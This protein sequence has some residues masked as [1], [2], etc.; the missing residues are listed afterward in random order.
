MI[1]TIEGLL[2]VMIHIL[3]MYV[4][5]YFLVLIMQSFGGVEN[6]DWVMFLKKFGVQIA[7]WH[8]LLS[9]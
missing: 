9:S 7:F 1:K 3:R 8:F 5:I 4:Y 2:F 6:I